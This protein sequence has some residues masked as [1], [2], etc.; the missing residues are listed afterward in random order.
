MLLG[1]GGMMN[2]DIS[3]G[4]SSTDGAAWWVGGGTVTV[5]RNASKSR[6][7]SKPGKTTGSGSSVVGVLFSSR[8]SSSP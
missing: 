5:A 6:F 8:P 3:S 1:G 4:V 2:E 7:K